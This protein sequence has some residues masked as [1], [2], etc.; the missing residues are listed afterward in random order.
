MVAVRCNRNKAA[1]QKHS[2]FV[3]GIPAATPLAALY[4]LYLR[5]VNYHHVS[6]LY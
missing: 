1:V 4:T 2:R 5:H 3:N 6:A